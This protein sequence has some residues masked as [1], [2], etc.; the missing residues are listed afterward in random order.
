[1]KKSW[2]PCRSCSKESFPGYKKQLDSSGREILYECDCHK[3]W[4]ESGIVESRLKESSIPYSDFIL[5]YDPSKNYFG[6]KKISGTVIKVTDL[7]SNS[8]DKS[9]LWFF[10]GKQGT[11]KTT[12]AWWMGAYFTKSNKSVYY[13]TM[14]KIIEETVGSFDEKKILRKKF[15]E[16]V[17]I[18]IIDD[19]FFKDRL[20]LFKNSNY[21][22]ALFN[23]LLRG[24]GES[25]NNLHTIVISSVPV[26]RIAAEGFGEDIEY[27]ISTRSLIELEFPDEY[28]KESAKFKMSDIFKKDN[29]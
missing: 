20:L 12:I 4:R 14:Q 22:L 26:N 3:V 2:I 29:K 6:D 17:P 28:K 15:Y 1:M 21:Q 25:I 18:L 9:S 11:Q 23:N 5:S 19:A 24:R 27:Y 8:T 16:E 10:H 7:I 13:T